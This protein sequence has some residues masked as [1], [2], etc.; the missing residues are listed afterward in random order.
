MKRSGFFKSS[1]SLFWRFA[2]LFLSLLLLFLGVSI[3]IVRVNA[4]NLRK[5]V[6]AQTETQFNADCRKMATSFYYISQLPYRLST[7]NDLNGTSTV[8][9]VLARLSRSG[10][11]NTEISPY[12]LRLN[13][14]LD[15]MKAVYQ[16]PQCYFV[17]YPNLQSGVS[18]SYENGRIFRKN[19]QTLDGYF[20]CEGLS[21]EEEMVFHS[22][23]TA[24][25]RS[26]APVNA[27]L[28]SLHRQKILP[29]LYEA[30]S[31]G[32]I[33]GFLYAENDFSQMLS[34]D[35]YPEGSWMEISAGGGSLVL[36][37]SQDRETTPVA[38]L[39]YS[40]RLPQLDIALHVPESYFENAVT[41]ANRSTRLI[42]AATAVLG[43]ICC[44]MLSGITVRPLRALTARH[45]MMTEGRQL[46]ELSAIEEFLTRSQER[47][48]SMER[49][50]ITS[51]ITCIFAGLPVNGKE[52][53]LLEPLFK[54]SL[55]VAILRLRG[56]I[57]ETEEAQTLIQLV[58]N[59]VHDSMISVYL[60]PQEVGLLLSSHEA[61][62]QALEEAVG[63]LRE[64]LT[65]DNPDCS[66]YCGIS[67][68]FDTPALLQ[69]AL[70]QAQMATPA[71]ESTIRYYEQFPL[72][73]ADTAENLE[74]TET[75]NLLTFQR[76]LESWNMDSITQEFSGYLIWFSHPGSEDPEG[77]WK[78]LLHIIRSF[79]LTN[80]MNVDAYQDLRYLRSA[81]PSTNFRGLLD[82]VEDLFDQRA[83]LPTNDRGILGQE[84]V[85]YVKEHFR[86]VRLCAGQLADFF[87]VSERFVYNA[88]I[89]ATGHNLSHLLHSMRVEEA[90]K[91]LTETN[92]GN[93]EISDACGFSAISTFYRVFKQYYHM[94]PM[95]YRELNRKHRG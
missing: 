53:E 93:Q 95:D 12:L 57:K 49:N 2:L 37:S 1:H 28:G 76:A 34:L 89:T 27:Q 62:C 51:L 71:G 70:K 31:Q 42:L 17:Y 78:C 32:C 18:L 30:P 16:L 68:P 8:F 94:A 84:I 10:A 60:H 13:D 29:I 50:L 3:F 75:L 45:Q 52:E 9:T 82:L 4:N 91:L 58:E 59:C 86:D 15:D 61:S 19:Y 46:N 44:L 48:S 11:A 5:Q 77:F 54:E 24:S 66:L 7:T 33:F 41:R 81:T 85:D 20:A 87:D 38:S 6:L 25:W 90:A 64:M 56:P 88:V 35:R 36:G 40:L 72:E 14:L 67:A 79:A 21:L 23:Y 63:Q 43:T 74:L 69:Q 22:V 39:K 47:S 92:L 73:S 65:R 83:Q 26:L 80:H 55:R